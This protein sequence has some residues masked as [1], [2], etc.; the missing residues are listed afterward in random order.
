MARFKLTEAQV[1]PTQPYRR[2]KAGTLICDGTACLVGDVIWTGLNASTYNQGM[3]PLDAG[4]DVIK[5]ASP[6][7]SIAPQNQIS[8][9]NSIDA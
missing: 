5:A 9:A 7:A 4:A 3:S 2:I 8:G 6:Y 1:F